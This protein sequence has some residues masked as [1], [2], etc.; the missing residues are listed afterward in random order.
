MGQV[1][2]VWGR[3]YQVLGF[4]CL[5]FV[6]FYFFFA[7][8]HFEIAP[9]TFRILKCDPYQK[10]FCCC[11]GGERKGDTYCWNPYL[12]FSAVLGVGSK[13]LLQLQMA[14]LAESYL[15]HFHLVYHHCK[16]FSWWN[17]NIR[18]SFFFALINSNY[19]CSFGV[20]HVLGPMPRAFSIFLQLIFTVM[21][22]HWDSISVKIVLSFS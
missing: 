18:S 1:L 6:A 2:L 9:E 3:F 16:V 20:S 22:E 8:Q 10:P 12:N 5:F 17:I 14:L 7:A 4:I 11:F 19:Q 13:P 21:Y 15:V